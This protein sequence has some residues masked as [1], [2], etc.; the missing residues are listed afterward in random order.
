MRTVANT[1]DCW[2]WDTRPSLKHLFDWAVHD[3]HAN[4]LTLAVRL[5]GAAGNRTPS[6]PG[7]ESWMQRTFD[8]RIIEQHLSRGWPAT[9]LM[10]HP[11]LVFL[12]Q[13]T[14]D[15]AEIMVKIEPSVFQWRHQHN[16]PLP[17]DICIFSAGAALPVFCSCTHENEAWLLAEKKPAIPGIR[18][19][20]LKIS[21]LL[22]PKH[23]N[24][25]T[26]WKDKN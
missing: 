14:A 9:E 20:K 24:F 2:T 16:P 11:G 19:C 8:D 25:I 7:L 17:E 3:R 18:P 13:L 15:L 1:V 26:P 21:E 23:P 12:L 5:E 10:G 6:V 4:R 22:I